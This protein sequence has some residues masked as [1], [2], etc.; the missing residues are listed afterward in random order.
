MLE[1]CKN[2]LASAKEVYNKSVELLNSIALNSKYLANVGLEI[3][4]VEKCKVIT[5]LSSEETLF[6]INLAHEVIYNT[7]NNGVDIYTD[8]AD[9]ITQLLSD[10]TVSYINLGGVA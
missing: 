3:G 5:A 8:N 2:N 4:A 6:Y 9:T 10:N 1:D 7:T